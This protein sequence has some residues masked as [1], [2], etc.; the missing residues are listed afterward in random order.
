MFYW[1]Q[2]SC[3]QLCQPKISHYG[4]YDTWIWFVETYTD[5]TWERYLD[6]AYYLLYIQRHFMRQNTFIQYCFFPT[7]FT[8][9]LLIMISAFL[10]T[11]MIFLIPAIRDKPTMF[12][13]MFFT[14]SLFFYLGILFIYMYFCENF[15]HVFYCVVRR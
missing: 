8:N 12:L 2:V 3:C 4:W 7:Y 11:C 1:L 5:H 6:G 10:Y 9:N 15:S 14:L 13:L